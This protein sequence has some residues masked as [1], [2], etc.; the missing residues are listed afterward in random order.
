MGYQE[1]NTGYALPR[2]QENYPSLLVYDSGVLHVLGENNK[3]LSN[4]PEELL[5]AVPRLPTQLDV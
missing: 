4:T 3:K 1:A 5:S 2:G